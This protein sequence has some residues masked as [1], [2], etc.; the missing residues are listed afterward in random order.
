MARYANAHPIQKSSRK[1]SELDP[2][3]SYT[4]EFTEDQRQKRLG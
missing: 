2:M 1:D 4:R 3:R